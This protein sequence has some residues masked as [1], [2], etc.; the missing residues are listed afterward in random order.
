VKIKLAYGKEGHTITLPDYYDMDLIEPSWNS[1]LPDPYK[2]V[3]EA[4]RNPIDSKPLKDLVK[5]EDKIGIIFSDITRPTPYNIITPAILN[6]LKFLPMENITF[7]CANGTHRLATEGELNKI[8]GEYVVGNFRIVQNDTSNIDLHD[9]VGT[10]RSGNKIFLNKEILNCTLKVL[11]GFIEPHFFAGFS[12]GGKSLIPG[13]ASLET[14]KHNHSIKN[15]LRKNV[16]WGKTYGNALWEDIQEASEFVPGLFLLNVTLNKNK[17]ITR[18]F[19][20]DLRSSHKEGCRYVKDSAMA[21]VN[22]LYDIVITSNSGYPLDLNIYQTVKGMSAAA[23]IVKP[24]GSIIIA[25]ECWDGIPSNS[26]YETILKSVKNVDELLQFIIDN[27]KT[28]K[29]TWQIYY[30]AIIQKKANVF[31]FSNKLKE[32][33]IKTAFLTPVKDIADLIGDLMRQKGPDACICLLPEGPQT[34]P[35]LRPDY[36]A[37]YALST[38]I[39]SP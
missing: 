32:E 19:A 35:Y 1:A 7:Y 28:L 31:L 29:D 17:E 34:I 13:L 26:D 16:R 36:N 20:G 3:I 33:A 27:E 9:Y 38:G 5:K 8:L 24:G 6:E 4:I 10:T 37:N 30:Q 21:P 14:I 2:S 23:G 11:T 18:V 15:L 22:R 12:G 39:I 25:A